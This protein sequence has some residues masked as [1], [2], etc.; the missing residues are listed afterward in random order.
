MTSPDTVHVARRYAL[1]SG[2]FVWVVIRFVFLIPFLRLQTCE[3]PPRLAV[4]AGLMGL[5]M[6]NISN[7]I[8]ICAHNISL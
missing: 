2:N 1:W 5:I 7:S 3:F 4:R 8:R 6:S